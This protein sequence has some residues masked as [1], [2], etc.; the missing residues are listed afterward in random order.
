MLLYNSSKTFTV[1]LE[2][3]VILELK[4]R[5]SVWSNYGDSSLISGTMKFAAVTP[6]LKRPLLDADHLKNYRPVCNPQFVSKVLERVVA[7]CLKAHMDINGLHDPFQLVY[8]TAH[9]TETALL[10]VQNDILRTVDTGGVMVLVLLDLSVAFVTID[11]AILLEYLRTLLGIDGMAH[12]CF[13]SY[14]TGRTQRVRIGEAWSLVK[15]LLFGILQ[16]SVL[17]P[18]LFLI[19]ILPLH[20]LIL[21]H[22]LSM[23]GYADDT[24]R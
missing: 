11:H 1:S 8:K 13:A 4:D 24:L 23:H 10:K 19:Y 9:G 16:G 5:N 7:S 21:S 6:L 3:I 20:C 14:L 15:F 12:A 17:G 18:L 22:R 2:E